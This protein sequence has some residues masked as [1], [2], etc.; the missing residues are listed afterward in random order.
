MSDSSKLKEKVVN[1]LLWKIGERLGVQG[2]QFLIQVVL[3]RILLPK[4]FGNVAII[5]VFI[6]I[7]TVLIQYGFSTALIQKI[8]ADELDISSAFWVNFA[9]SSLMYI[10]LFICAPLLGTFYND[11]A[12]ASMLRVQAIILFLG[13]FSSIQ[14]AILAKEMD[15]KKSFFINFGGIVA[16]GVIGIG[17]AINR[18]GIWSL[19]FAQIANSFVIVVLGFIFVSW[20]PSF[21]FSYHKVKQLFTFGKNILLASL[22]ETICNNIYSLTI[23]KVF[24]KE[25]LGYYNRGQSI[26][27]M[28]TNTIDGSIQGVLFP[29]LSTYQNDLEQMK[30]LMRRAIRT[31]CYLIFPIMG[32][33]I[34]IANPLI[35]FLLTDKWLPAVPF[36]QMSCLSMAFYPI[37]TANLQAINAS[38]KSDIYLKLE[39]IKKTLLIVILLIT[40]QFNIYIVMAGSVVC[41]IVSIVINSWPNKR[42]FNYSIIEQLKDVMPSMVLSTIMCLIISYIEALL[43]CSAFLSLVVGVL[44]GVIIYVLGSLIFKIEEFFYLKDSVLEF[45]KRLFEKKE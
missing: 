8:D 9:I 28:L 26:P 32:G 27:N 17:L 13:A 16:Q 18:A 31:S 45:I 30:R 20:R 23:G 36:L 33:I 42:L 12:L 3:A 2:M 41:S 10:L 15:F 39:V 35:S 14:N 7:A 29:A 21:S 24:S 44:L 1:G 40:L 22:L 19:V 43:N 25:A 4:D 5:N 11:G 38:G 34:A 6:L 37:H